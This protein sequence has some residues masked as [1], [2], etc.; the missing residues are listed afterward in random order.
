M[1]TQV[2]KR[3]TRKIDESELEQAGLMP[4]AN[5]G[6][7]VETEDVLPDI[8]PE[9]ITNHLPPLNKVVPMIAY[10]IGGLTLVGVLL[11]LIGFYILFYSWIIDGFS[12]FTSASLFCI[13]VGLACIGF[14]AYYVLTHKRGSK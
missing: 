3:S 9:L 12:H 8:S 2:S 11:A 5:N 13:F 1:A 7:E 4:A 14:C 10:I 6:N